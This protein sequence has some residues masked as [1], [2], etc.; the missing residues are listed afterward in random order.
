MTARLFASV[1]SVAFTAGAAEWSQSLWL[2][3]GDV[4]RA[5]FPVALSNATVQALEGVSSR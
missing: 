1:L 3:R 5:R 4:W 2:G